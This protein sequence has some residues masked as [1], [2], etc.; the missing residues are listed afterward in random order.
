MGI[1]KELRGVIQKQLRFGN[2][3]WLRASALVGRVN[4]L[5]KLEEVGS[6]K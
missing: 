6:S 5:Q 3:W 4:V 1:I 2:Q